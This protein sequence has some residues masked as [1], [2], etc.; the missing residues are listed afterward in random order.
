MA[1]RAA[2]GSISVD[3][4]YSGSKTVQTDGAFVLRTLVK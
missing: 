1:G 3:V 2:E 4:T